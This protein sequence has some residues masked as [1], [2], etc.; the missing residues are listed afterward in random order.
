MDNTNDSPVQ[1]A[2]S[3]ATLQKA[4]KRGFLNRNA[5]KYLVVIAMVMDH[6]AVCFSDQIPGASYNL[7]RVFGRVVSP[8]FAFFIAEGFMHTS[9]IVKYKIR[10]A[11]LALISW[12]ACLF[13]FFGI[14]KLKESPEMLVGQSVVFAFVLALVALSVW[15]SEKLKIGVKIFLIV[16]L[17][18]L[19]LI[20]DMPFAG[21]L[22]P[23]FHVIFKDN[24]IKRYISLALT[25]M[26]MVI[27][28]I[29]SQGWFW[30]GI[31]L[32]PILLIFCYN[33]ESGKKNAFNK[34][35]FYAFYPAHLIVLG[36]L[37]WYVF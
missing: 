32:A 21:V 29:F 31:L 22:A 37:R 9:N 35:F 7:L 17:T 4:E 15:H 1:R 8:V 30:L 33:G 20:S 16:L 36:I 10:I 18:A 6:I 25:Y 5:L 12:V 34:W 26:V 14:E 27:P 28:V 11:I 24:K 23:L 2:G 3:A 19:S 13:C